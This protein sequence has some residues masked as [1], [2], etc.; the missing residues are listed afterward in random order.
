MEYRRKI[1]S[2]RTFNI[3]QFKNYYRSLNSDIIPGNSLKIIYK[4]LEPYIANLQKFE[5]IEQ[6]WKQNISIKKIKYYYL[7]ENKKFIS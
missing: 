3:R 7:L 5:N 4:I 6:K 1:N 2:N